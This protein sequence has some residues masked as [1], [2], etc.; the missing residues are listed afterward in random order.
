MANQYIHAETGLNLGYIHQSS[1][2]VGPTSGQL[3]WSVGHTSAD[4]TQPLV[5]CLT[6]PD[7]A[8]KPK[9]TIP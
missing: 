3:V 9:P 4:A 7:L 2:A 1:P 5:T 6:Y 8:V